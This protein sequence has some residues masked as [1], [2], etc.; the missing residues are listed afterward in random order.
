VTVRLAGAPGPPRPPEE[1]PYDPRIT[2]D[3]ARVR[4][5]YILTG[6]LVGIVALSFLILIIVVYNPPPGTTA[7]ATSPAITALDSLL[8]L[9]FAPVIGLVGS[10][11]GFYFGGRTAKEASREPEGRE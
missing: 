9:V 10:V 2:T 4:L 6:L 11:L 3:T 8:K 1:E 5:A 7:G